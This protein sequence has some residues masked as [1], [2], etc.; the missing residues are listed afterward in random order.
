MWILTLGGYMYRWSRG[1]ANTVERACSRVDLWEDCTEWRCSMLVNTH[2]LQIW[3]SCL[4]FQYCYYTLPLSAMPNTRI[5]VSALTNANSLHCWFSV[6]MQLWAKQIFAKNCMPLSRKDILNYTVTL[7]GNMYK[8]Q[9]QIRGITQSYVCLR[10][11]C[12]LGVLYSDGYLDHL[13]WMT[14][15]AKQF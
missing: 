11:A 5:P 4:I 6:L 10:C 13:K 15:I 9:T 2:F 1:A 12:T 14:C 7:F 3:N 8:R